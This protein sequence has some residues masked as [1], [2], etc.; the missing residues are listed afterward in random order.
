MVVV[1]QNLQFATA[2][3]ERMVVM[4]AGRVAVETTATVMR[5]DVEAQQRYLGVTR[6]EA[7]GAPGEPGR[8]EPPQQSLRPETGGSQ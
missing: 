7:E 2:L 6:L 8:V 3:A 4:V 1:E 5:S